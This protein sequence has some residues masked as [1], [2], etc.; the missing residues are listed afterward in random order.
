[1]PRKTVHTDA[2]SPSNA[3]M[4]SVQFY[5]ASRPQAPERHKNDSA[6]A[7]LVEC[8]VC[9]GLFFPDTKEAKATH[10]AW[11]VANT[12]QVQSDGTGTTRYVRMPCRLAT[13][14]YEARYQFE[15]SCGLCGEDLC[16]CLECV[17]RHPVECGMWRKVGELVKAGKET[18]ADRLSDEI[19]AARVTHA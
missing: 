3:P 16:P 6:L 17:E 18:E 12:I 4:K 13:A 19:L 8:S 10:K 11:H 1:M 2:N 5:K 14:A 7:L 9:R 15:T